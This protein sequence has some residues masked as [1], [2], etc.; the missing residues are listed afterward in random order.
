MTQL[1]V[2]F[3][4]PPLPNPIPNT[5]LYVYV[6]GGSHTSTEKYTM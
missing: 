6:V 2:T 3:R 4:S 5:P 1:T